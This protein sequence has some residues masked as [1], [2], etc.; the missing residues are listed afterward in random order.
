MF[1]VNNKGVTDVVLPSL[2]STLNK[3]HDAVLASLLLILN[4]FHTLL[5]CCYC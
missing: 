5:W 2:L 4:I 3:F 1:K